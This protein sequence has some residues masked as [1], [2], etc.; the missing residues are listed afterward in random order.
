MENYVW[1]ACYGSNINGLRFFLYIQ[2]GSHFFDGIKITNQGC[3][4]QRLPI[5]MK[6]FL[7]KHPIY[8]AKYS[9]TW[10]GGVAFLDITKKGFSYGKAYLV[11]EEQFKSIMKQEGT[12]YPIEV[13]LGILDGYPIKTFTGIHEDLNKPSFSYIN[14]IKNG[15]IDLGISESEINTYLNDHL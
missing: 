11:T 6:P 2:G 14:T 7:F 9:T 4:D 5:Q 3:F 12:W 15:L 8:F 13:D 1:Y 10:E